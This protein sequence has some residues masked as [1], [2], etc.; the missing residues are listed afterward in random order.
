MFKIQL[1]KKKK[2][3]PSYQETGILKLEYKK[4]INWD[5]SDVEVIWEGI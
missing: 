1:K 4:K 2:S 5:E 3:H